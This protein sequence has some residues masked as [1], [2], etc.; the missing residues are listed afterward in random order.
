MGGN[1][2]TWN[3]DYI[4]NDEATELSG[5]I[6]DNLKDKPDTPPLFRETY[7]TPEMIAAGVKA[8]MAFEDNE[9]VDA[10]EQ[11]VSRI[12]CAMH[13]AAPV[14]LVSEG[15]RQAVRKRDEA[16]EIRDLA[17]ARVGEL[18]AEIEPLRRQVLTEKA[19]NNS[20]N[21]ALAQSERENAD[22]RA[23]MDDDPKPAPATDVDRVVD[24]LDRRVV[25]QG[26]RTR[27]RGALDKA[28]APQVGR[29][30]ADK[31]VGRAIGGRA[32]GAAHSGLRVP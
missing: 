7:I 32:G 11:E 10:D 1:N 4:W 8:M 6:W 18:M 3:Y 29:A 13:A 20:A 5:D 14:E 28:D 19:W 21:A 2:P 9:A 22:M 17:L 15:E 26:D 24:A 23:A 12:F 31:G 27:L 16:L 25:P 30:G